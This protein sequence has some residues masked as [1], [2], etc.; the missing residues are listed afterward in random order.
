MKGLRSLGARLLASHLAVMATS[1][2][3]VLLVAHV[4]APA[5][6]RD[7]LDSMSQMMNGAMTSAMEAEL[8]AGFSSAFARALVFA[9]LIGI[10]VA[11][12]LAVVGSRRVVK[13]I[14]EVRRAT[15]RLA[16][17]HY[18]ARLDPPAEEELA[19]LVEDVNFL[20]ETLAAT[21]ERRL[22]LLGEVSHELRTP[23]TTIE[24][25]MEAMLDGVLEPT[26]DILASV[27]HEASRLKRLAADIA[28]LS[29]AEE[30]TLE[31]D[32]EEVDLGELA[33]GVVMRLQPQFEEADVRVTVVSPSRCPV[34]ADADRIIQILTNLVG[35][36]LTYTPAEGEVKIVVEAN[37][38]EARVHVVDTGQGIDPE[39]AERIFERFQRGDRSAP[40]GMG[41]GLSIARSLAQLHGGSLTVESP[42]L[43]EGS[44]FTLTIP[45]TAGYTNS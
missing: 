17:G 27:A 22:R 36:A 25:Y 42:G 29:S 6:Y 2:V 21:E 28:L 44:R 23:L 32:P 19:A 26:P 1:V 4:L 11:A 13:P 7:H 33:V 31:L 45:K 39:D 20:A 16:S 34:V 38:D 40:G 5:F 3:T 35:N 43:G 24:G 9:V 14:D 15:R 30:A 10:A 41:V 8:E 37:R 18:R 12:I